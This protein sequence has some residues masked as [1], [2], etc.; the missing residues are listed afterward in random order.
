MRKE[1]SNIL[2]LKSTEAIKKNR[3]FQK[4]VSEDNDS[5]DFNSVPDSIAAFQ[6]KDLN[7]YST[8]QH[9]F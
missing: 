5:N 7:L 6:G 9:G 4:V 1:N 2:L 8:S 3:C